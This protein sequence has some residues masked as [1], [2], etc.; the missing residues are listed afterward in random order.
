MKIAIIG[1]SAG[2]GLAAVNQ[3]L[4]R[5]H[6]VSALSRNTESIP[7]H[8]FLT[9][10]NGSATSVSD[11]KKVIQDVDSIL[12]TIGTKD[13]K[14]TTLFSE[15]ARALIEAIRETNPDIP[16]LIITGFG[17]GESKNYLNL[18]MKLVIRFFLK[19]QYVDK[20]LMEQMITQS[21]LKWEIIRPGMLT[22]GKRTN[23]YQI[24]TKLERDI[25]IG[26]IARA[27]VADFLLNQAENPGL[28]YQFPA[29]TS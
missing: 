8:K 21:N 24:K 27:D 1:A 18:F 22:D 2:I 20:T 4:E 19:D 13:K 5:G 29:L 7:D 10:I 26:K 17:A 12:V 14:N 28:L 3:A 9:K 23:R 25:K 11:L 6:Q 15:T 16:V